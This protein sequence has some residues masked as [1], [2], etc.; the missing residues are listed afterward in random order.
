MR[1]V[2]NTAIIKHSEVLFVSQINK[3]KI[4]FFFGTPLI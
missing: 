3:E 1:Q 2:H 4:L